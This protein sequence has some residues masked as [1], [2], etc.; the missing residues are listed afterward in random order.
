MSPLAVVIERENYIIVCHY[1]L[2]LLDADEKKW[3]LVAIWE[4]SRVLIL[5]IGIQKAL[6]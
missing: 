2:S 1:Q 4:S 5:K 3:M 6:F